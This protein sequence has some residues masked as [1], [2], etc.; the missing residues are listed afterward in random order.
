MRSIHLL[1][2]ILLITAGNSN[3]QIGYGVEA[4][5]GMATMKFAPPL[6]PVTYTSASVS[7]ITGGKVGC[8]IDVPLE[9]K[10]YFQSGFSVSRQ[11]AV[12]SFSYFRNDSFNESVHQQLN[13][14]YFDVPVVALYKSGMQGTGRLVAGIGV[15]LS[16]LISGQNILKDHSVYND[17]LSDNSNT[18][19]IVAGQTLSGFNI[20]V[21]LSGGYELASG[22]FFRGYYTVG[23]KDLGI[24]TEIDKTRSFGISAGYFFGK[25]RN[26]NKEKNDLIDHSTP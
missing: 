19:K 8:L 4:G 17:T 22:L 21:N 23:A 1:L 7:P 20:C 15:T 6:T 3:A 24:G 5:I 18:Y 9:N 25:G 13:I 26:I 14:N 16:Y 12:R 11:G 10:I 2:A